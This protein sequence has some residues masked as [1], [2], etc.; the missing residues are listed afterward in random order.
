VRAPVPGGGSCQG[1]RDQRA[2][3]VHQLVRRGRV[4]AQSRIGRPQG[5]GRA[6]C[7]G[8]GGQLPWGQTTTAVGC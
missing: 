3:R 2:R 1:V 7:A 5:G 6:G 8:C 4:M